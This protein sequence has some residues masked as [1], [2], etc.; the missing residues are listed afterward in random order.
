[1]VCEAVRLLNTAVDWITVT[2]VLPLTAK[3]L[4]PAVTWLVPD[5]TAVK[6]PLALMM[7]VAGVLL[8]QAVSS[9][10]NTCNVELAV[11]PGPPPATYS[12]PPMAT[13]V[14]S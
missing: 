6:L 13:G 10:I 8:V 5:E 9:G 3:A 14:L 2:C 7:A 4:L 12:S 11:S 1:M